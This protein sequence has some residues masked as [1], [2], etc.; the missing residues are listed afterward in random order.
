M[1]KTDFVVALEQVSAALLNIGIEARQP[2]LLIRFK[3]HHV[4]LRHLAGDASLILGDKISRARFGRS[5]R[6]GQ[7]PLLGSRKK[8][9]INRKRLALDVREHYCARV[10][11]TSPAGQG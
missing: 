1:A 5:G 9:G 7:A 11:I 2:N 8:T 3:K 6:S 10:R 4:S